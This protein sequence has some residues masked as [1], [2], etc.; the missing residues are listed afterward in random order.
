M[1]ISRGKGRQ[2]C[3]T[4]ALGSGQRERHCGAQPPLPHTAGNLRLLLLQQQQ[5]VILLVKLLLPQHLLLKLLGGDQPH[6]L[7]LQIAAPHGQG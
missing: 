6:R 7:L 3:R 4:G 5:L 1:R 2:A